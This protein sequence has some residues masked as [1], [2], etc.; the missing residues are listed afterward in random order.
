M[1]M[2]DEL[3]KTAL[4]H[5]MAAVETDDPDTVHRL[6]E[7]AHDCVRSAAMEAASCYAV[8][9]RIKAPTRGS[10]SLGRSIS[11]GLTGSSSS[12]PIG[13]GR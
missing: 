7:S 4:K 8:V 3:R 5:F 6:L 10:L 2:R 12:S 9:W 13:D 11:T 1:S